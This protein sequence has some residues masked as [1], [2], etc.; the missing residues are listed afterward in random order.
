MEK[1]N[2]KLIIVALLAFVAGAFMGN[3][4]TMMYVSSGTHQSAPPA[5]SAPATADALTSLKTATAAHPDDPSA[6]I[7]L[8]NYYFDHEQPKLAI[9]AYEKALELA[10]GNPNVWSDLGVMYRRSGNPEKAVD[11]FAHA[12]SLDTEHTTSL[13]NKGIVL[14]YDLGRKQEAVEAW[15]A[16]LRKDPQAKAPNGMPVAEFI[17]MAQEQ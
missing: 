11:A 15:Q 1:G 5:A 2:S 7:A 6:W 12:A 3:A 4:L 14:F 13:F 8:G 9:P 10:P 16:I 17:K